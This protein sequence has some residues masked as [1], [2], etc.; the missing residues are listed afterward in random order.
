MLEVLPES[1]R[2][3]LARHTVVLTLILRLV[4]LP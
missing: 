3:R 1:R 4:N 2:I